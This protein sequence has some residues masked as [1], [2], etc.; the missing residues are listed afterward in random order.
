[1]CV[2]QCEDRFHN[3]MKIWDNRFSH[4]INPKL[5]S[6][7]LPLTKVNKKSFILF[8]HQEKKTNFTKQN[9]HLPVHKRSSSVPYLTKWVVDIL[10]WVKFFAQVWKIEM[11][12]EYYCIFGKKIITIW[13]KKLNF[14]CHIFIWFW[15]GSNFYLYFLRFRYILKTYCHLTWRLIG[16]FTTDTISKKKKKTLMDSAYSMVW[17]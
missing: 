2:F 5:P 14:F 15:F 4:L 10:F 13:R 3:K 16:M 6:H 12:R 17:K 11:K 9:A 8:S 1:M 7:V